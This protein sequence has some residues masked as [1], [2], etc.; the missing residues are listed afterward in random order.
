MR[1]DAK[2][3]EKYCLNCGQRLERKRYGRRLEEF[4][5]FLRRKFCNMKCMGEY[6]TIDHPTKE[7]IRK[8][9]QKIQMKNRCEKCGTK[10]NLQ[11]H[12]PDYSKPELIMT[13]CQDCHKNVHLVDGSWARSGHQESKICPVCGKIVIRE[14]GVGR[15]DFFRTRTCSRRCGWELRRRKG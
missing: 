3:A 14:R 2:S 10:K 11:R 6:K 1:S 8:R 4:Q 15:R 13:L 7:T 9:A 5:N 12:H